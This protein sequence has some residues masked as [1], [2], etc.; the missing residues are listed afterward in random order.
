MCHG[1]PRLA[2]GPPHPS[3]LQ[4]C[5][6]APPQRRDLVPP[7]S[8]RI[9]DVFGKMRY[10]IGSVSERLRNRNPSGSACRGSNPPAVAPRQHS[11]P[12]RWLASRSGV[13][14][15]L[16]GQDTQLSPERPGFESQWRNFLLRS[17]HCLLQRSVFLYLLLQCGPLA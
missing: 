12:H 16:A 7:A 14:Y 5:G 17:G 3:Q 11:R 2:G 4:A 1:C 6:P 9:K 10:I 13:R 8:H 15:N